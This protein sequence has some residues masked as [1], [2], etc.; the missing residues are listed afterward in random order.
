MY[1]LHRGTDND[2]TKLEGCL[3]VIPFTHLT[4]GR[5]LP[6]CKC[7]TWMFF[8]ILPSSIM[9]HHSTFLTNGLIKGEGRTKAWGIRE[10]RSMKRGQKT[11]QES[12]F[13]MW[14][15]SQ[16]LIMII[17]LHLF[18]EDFCNIYC[19]KDSPTHYFF[20]SSQHTWG[21]QCSII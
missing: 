10:V 20:S 8:C 2:Q 17:N 11:V 15:Y 13:P 5:A 19:A 9:S 21:K 4:W 18:T 3:R 1:I 12:S 7:V 14:N 6:K 16:I